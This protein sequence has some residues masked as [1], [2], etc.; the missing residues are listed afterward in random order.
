ME[1]YT[2]HRPSWPYDFEQLMILAHGIVLNCHKLFL[3]NPAFH[4]IF[5]NLEQL[6][7]LLHNV[8]LEKIICDFWA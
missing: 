1:V 5:L 8:R 7:K 2:M 3:R 4:P 6:I